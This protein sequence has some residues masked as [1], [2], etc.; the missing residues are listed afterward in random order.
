MR[1]CADLD[2]FLRQFV[3]IE[4]CESS[5]VY[6]RHDTKAGLPAFMYARVCYC[7]NLLNG[8]SKI[9]WESKN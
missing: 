1:V 9:S 8:D 3:P 4:L 6:I 7:S 5:R 2:F